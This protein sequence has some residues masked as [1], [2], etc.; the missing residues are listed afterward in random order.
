LKLRIATLTIMMFA[1]VAIPSMAQN[2]IY[3]NGPID[4]N[5]DAWT[6][7]FGFVVSDAFTLDSASTVNGLTF[8]TWMFAGDV[9]QTADVSITSDEFGGT[10]FFSGTVNFTQSGCVGN[11]FGFNV[12]T[13]TGSFSGVNL[14]AGTYWLNLQNAV[15]SNGD[16]VYWD[17]NGGPS[18]ASESSVGSIPSEAF[19]LIGHTGGGGGTTP[20][21]SSILLL[22][23]G[24]LGV[25]GVMRR[26]LF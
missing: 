4:G 1:L 11:G 19:S 20:E 16:P 7:N 26:K 24:I 14:N 12:C 5:T 6:I 10:T 25:A 2:V 18:S 8:G 22:S 23:S 9:L 3:D 21:P 17:E 13:E 15:V